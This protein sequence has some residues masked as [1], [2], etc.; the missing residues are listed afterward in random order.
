MRRDF[1]FLIFVPLQSVISQLVLR[2]RHLFSSSRVRTLTLP[3]GAR[4]TKFSGGQ[5]LLFL[6]EGIGQI[7]IKEIPQSF[8]K[9]ENCTE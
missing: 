2:H 7:P 9:R 8:C 4:C 6:T 5:A 1:Y 3:S